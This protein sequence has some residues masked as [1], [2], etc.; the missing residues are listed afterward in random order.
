LME[1]PRFGHRMLLT[2]SCLFQILDGICLPV[3]IMQDILHQGGFETKN[4]LE[5]YWMHISFTSRGIRSL[6]LRKVALVSKF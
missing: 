1:I 4:V 3:G 6:P 5:S 2:F